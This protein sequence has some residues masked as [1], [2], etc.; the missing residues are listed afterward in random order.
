M[1]P[2]QQNEDEEFKIFT[3]ENIE[4]IIHIND[5]LKKEEE[6]ILPFAQKLYASLEQSLEQKEIYDYNFNSNLQVY[7]LVDACNKRHNCEEGDYIYAE[8]FSLFGKHNLDANDIFYTDN[9]NL[10]LKGDHPLAN[11][12]F[13]YSM[14]CI[15]F[16]SG[17][18]WQDI[19]DI[20]F[21]WIDLKV[22]YQ[23]M[24]CY[25][26]NYYKQVEIKTDS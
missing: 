16:H 15:C 14:H 23:F 7:S 2:E 1:H 4:K 25:D 9:W 6:R 17:L 12:P 21:V 24:I 19:L 22:D 26:D 20:G 8:S 10:Y 5:L 11:I 13:C 18:S 3:K